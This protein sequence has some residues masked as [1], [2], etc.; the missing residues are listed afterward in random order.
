MKL[1]LPV[2]KETIGQFLSRYHYL[3]FFV[4]IVSSLS[5]A[6]FILNQTIVSSDN[7]GDYKAQTSETT[8]FDTATIEKLRQLRTTN[9]AP[10]SQL[11][12]GGGRIS[13]F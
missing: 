13:P 7:A 11:D 2:I 12:L 1:S 9:E 3:I 8:Q 5:V 10:G 6:M 4:I